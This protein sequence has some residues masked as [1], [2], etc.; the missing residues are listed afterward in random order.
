MDEVSNSLISRERISKQY[1]LAIYSYLSPVGLFGLHIVDAYTFRL[2]DALFFA[3]AVL[4]LLPSGCAGLFFTAK[5][6]A[7]AVK[8]NDYQKKDIGY[9][10]LTMG[11]IIVIAGLLGAG[12]A[13]VMVSN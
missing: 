11:I 12:L 7:M 5:G 13:Y 4:S 6:I 9:A 1:R 2:T 10:N 3:V 8:N